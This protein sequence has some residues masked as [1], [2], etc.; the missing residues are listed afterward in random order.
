VN[1][2]DKPV[3]GTGYSRKL[4]EQNAAEAVLAS[5]GIA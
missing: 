1:L 3:R 5:L 2:L 4:A